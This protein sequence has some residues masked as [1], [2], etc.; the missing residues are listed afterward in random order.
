[1][2]TDT[3]STKR[4]SEGVV[5]R[6]GA[7]AEAAPSELREDELFFPRM[8]G[9]TGLMFAVLGTM[10]VLFNLI[11]GPR[12]L[13]LEWGAVFLTGGLGGMLYHAARD[14]DLLVRR[15][16][17]MF[18]FILFGVTLLLSVI[19]AKEMGLGALFLPYGGLTLLVGLFFLMAFARHETEEGW[20]KAI[21]FT[22]MLG[23]L[24]MALGT[25]ATTIFL[26][27][28]L[29][30]TGAFLMLMGLAFLCSFVGQTG[31]DDG[32]G[33]KI[34][35]AILAM[36]VLF[37][38]YGVLRPVGGQYLFDWGVLDTLPKPFLVPTGLIL[39]A[40]GLVYA[41]VGLGILSENRIVVMTRRELTSFFY[42]P[43]AYIVMFALALIGWITY[44]LFVGQLIRRGAVEEPILQDYAL[45]FPAVVAVLFA[46]PALTMRLLSEERRLGTLEVLLTSPVNEVQIVL[47][48]FFAVWIFFLIM[49]LPWGGYL[50]ALRTI[51]GTPFDFL[52]MV[53]FYLAF[54]SSAAMFLSM[55]LFF[56][57]LTRNQIVAAVL[58]FMGMLGM[59]GLTLLSVMSVQ[60][61]EFWQNLFARLAFL[62]MWSEAMAG[63]LPIRDVIL[64]LSVTV[65]WLFLTV[66]V[67][68][69][70]RWS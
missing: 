1:M 8:I 18:A 31:S 57:S 38:L 34:S 61:G 63:R 62:S 12:V 6:V 30:G 65:F 42:S 58:T 28:F 21:R 39:I 52:P 67:L 11:W 37:L 47:S 7:I 54:A 5:L 24:G 41:G 55:G 3:Q 23:G 16:Y 4:S 50:I 64:Q 40:A 49:W 43:I 26:P 10:I 68:E 20:R 25:F 60:V 48:K 59:I 46:V 15:Y 56:S 22:L 29:T 9:S 53:S 69:A 35:Q 14:A 33:Y 27:D 17:G 45:N 19:P 51:G 2:A 13:G 70:R 32:I 36:G 44:F 66:K